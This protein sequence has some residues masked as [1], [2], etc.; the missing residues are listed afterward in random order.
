MKSISRIVSLSLLAAATWLPIKSE[1]QDII[2]I[3]NLSENM[4]LTLNRQ[5][6]KSLFMGGARSYDLKVVALPPEHPV[7]VAFNT[8]VIGLTEARIQSYWAQMRF[9]GRKKP[10]LKVGNETEMLEYLQITPN[11]VGYI[12]ANTP[13]PDSLKII[14][15]SS[16]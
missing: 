8:K 3:A 14:F 5:E 12:S 7:R 1:A 10:P 15:N 4:S 11:A 2:L 6:V 9:S 16:D 13:V